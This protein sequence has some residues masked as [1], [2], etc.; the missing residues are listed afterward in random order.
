MIILLKLSGV[1][2]AF[3][4]IG[5][6]LGISQYESWLIG[7]IIGTLFLIAFSLQVVQPSGFDPSETLES[8]G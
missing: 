6:N 8:T 5:V 4:A 7:S 3:L 2:L 1:I